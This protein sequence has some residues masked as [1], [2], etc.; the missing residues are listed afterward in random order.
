MKIKYWK[1]AVLMCV[2]SILYSLAI[3]MGTLG[4]EL[5]LSRFVAFKFTLC[6]AVVGLTF[7]IAGSIQLIR[8]YAREKIK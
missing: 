3:L 2:G 7:Y 4:P 5:G 1:F 8:Q 6:F